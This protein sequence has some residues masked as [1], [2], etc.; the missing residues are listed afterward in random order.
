MT[1]KIHLNE[2]ANKENLYTSKQIN[3][4]NDISIDNDR[5]LFSYYSTFI[6]KF[7]FLICFVFIIIAG[8]YLNLQ[9]LKSLISKYWNFPFLYSYNN[10]DVY[11]DYIFLNDCNDN[12]ESIEKNEIYEKLIK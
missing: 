2:N 5:K 4:Y 8:V 12:I 11:K 7:Y 1:E 10:Y 6:S 9:K 3:S